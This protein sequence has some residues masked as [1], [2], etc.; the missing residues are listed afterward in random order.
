[1]F[2]YVLNNGTAN[3]VTPISFTDRCIIRS[4][5]NAFTLIKTDGETIEEHRDPQLDVHH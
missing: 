5:T 3:S 2:L 4:A 1:V